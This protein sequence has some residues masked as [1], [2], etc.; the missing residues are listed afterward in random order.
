MLSCLSW[1]KAPEE[2]QAHDGLNELNLLLCDF[3]REL[4]K[5]RF[6]MMKLIRP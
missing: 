2:I 3:A 1:C 5:R 6:R 4:L